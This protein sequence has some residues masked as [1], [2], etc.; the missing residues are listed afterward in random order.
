[1]QKIKITNLQSPKRLD[2]YLC[3]ELKESR[4]Y[5]AMLNANSKILVNGKIVKN[6]FLVK[7]GDEI[8]IEYIIPLKLEPIKMDLEIVYEDEYLMVINKPK[9]LVVHPAS[10]Y[11]E[12]TLVHGLLEKLSSSMDNSLRPGI[13]HRIDKD[14]SGLLLVAKTPTILDK[15]SSSLKEHKV[16]R[17]YYALVNGVVSEDEVTITTYL[18]RDPK[19]RLRFCVTSNSTNAKLAIT[20]YKVIQKYDHFTLLEVKLETGRTHQIRVH[21][22]SIGHPIY[23]D[24]LYGDKHNKEGQY[25]HAKSLGFIHPIS[26]KYCFFDSPL[27]PYMAKFLDELI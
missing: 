3:E 1:M 5:F 15:L 16:D 24:S 13:V 19:N 20:H 14:T 22:S 8:E 27:P 21:L 12:A 9:G 6:G 4:S 17:I 23:G 7:D 11:K 26:G 25:L 10:S 2:V 18:K